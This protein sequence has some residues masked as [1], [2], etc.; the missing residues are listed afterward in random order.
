MCES[1]QP[2]IQAV[3][4]FARTNKWANDQYDLQ[5]ARHDKHVS[6]P[7]QS[8]PPADI[9]EPCATETLD[10]KHLKLDTTNLGI[11]KDC[12]EYKEKIARRKEAI[13][14]KIRRIVT[15]GCV[16]TG[17]PELIVRVAPGTGS[18]ASTVELKCDICWYCSKCNDPII[19]HSVRA[20]RRLLKTGD[21]DIDAK[22][23]QVESLPADR[24]N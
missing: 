21:P 16:K 10:L 6:I 14:K 5:T 8:L 12:P 1:M 4:P 9:S 11:Y 17:N 13:D 2:A 20:L 7:A 18:T 15:L 22:V 24:K 3:E 19:D 23:V